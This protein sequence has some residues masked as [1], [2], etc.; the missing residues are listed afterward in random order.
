V[1]V[2]VAG[3]DQ[4]GDPIVVE[5]KLRSSFACSSVGIVDLILVGECERLLDVTSPYGWPHLKPAFPIRS[6]QHFLD[7]F[8]TL[9]AGIAR[10]YGLDNVLFGDDSISDPVGES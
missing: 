6:P 9:R 7:I 8:L 2:E 10:A 1:V 3:V 5:T 4:L